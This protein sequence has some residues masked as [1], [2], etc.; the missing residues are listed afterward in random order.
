MARK[1][2][3]T[4]QAAEY[5]SV[6]PDTI[7]R[8]IRSGILPA[9]RTAG[10]HH[11]IDE[12]DLDR[13]LNLRGDRKGAALDG[14]FRRF[15]YCWE[16]NEEGKLNEGCKKCA[17]YLMRAQRCYEFGKFAADDFH[18]KIYCKTTC[19]ECDYFKE[20]HGR[21]TNVLVVTD[22]GQLASSLKKAAEATRFSLE[23]VDCEYTCSM[24]VDRFKPDFVI[25]DCSLGQGASRDITHHLAEDPRVPFVRVVLAGNEGEFPTECEKVIFARLNRPFGVDDI[26]E[27]IAGTM[28]DREGGSP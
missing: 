8:W 21:T 17:V 22:D 24:A 10:G 26:E 19:E 16:F 1:F 4:G 2:L 7:L 12:R 27:C 9:R 11:R 6:T 28:L 3:T 13:I 20:V 18:P 25:V 23:V 5:C 14:L 15:R